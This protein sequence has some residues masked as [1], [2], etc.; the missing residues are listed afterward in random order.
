MSNETNLSKFEKIKLA[1]ENLET[2]NFKILIFSPDTNQVATST[3]YQLY[4]NVK[5]LRNAGY[6]AYILSEKKDYA[7]PEWIEDEMKDIPHISIEEGLSAGP[8]DFL[9]IPEIFTNLM[10]QWKDFP[11]EKIVICQ[12]YDYMLDGLLPGISWSMFNIKNVITIS[13]DLKNFIKETFG[14]FNVKK[15]KIGI[16]EYFVKSSKP[17]IPLIGFI[18]RNPHD[19]QKLVKVFYA[20]YPHF[21]FLTFEDMRGK[22]RPDFAKTLG[23]CFLSVWI[24]RIASFGTFPVESMKC[25]TLVIGLIPDKKPEYIVEN[26]GIWAY[27]IYQ[28]A[29]F[30]AQATSA[31]IE[32]NVGEVFYST[33]KEV[34]SQ[35]TQTESEKEIVK[36]YDEFV[37]ERIKMFENVV[38]QQVNSFVVE[39]EAV[40]VVNNEGDADNVT[41]SG[42]VGPF[43]E[44]SNHRDTNPSAE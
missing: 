28:M 14:D 21:R 44:L 31:W 8:E 22:T 30:I 2:K 12:S 25:G 38:S 35:Y 9:V 15:Y 13:D 42:D 36:I 39:G 5:A 10:D 24:D 26:S 20:K 7:K 3:V 6:N 32:D 1:K 33:M 17:K 29:D 23:E 19:I 18:S 40:M 43:E 34:S 11:C 41:E 37:S 4:F 27:D 16:P